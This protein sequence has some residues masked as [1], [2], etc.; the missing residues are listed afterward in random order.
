MHVPVS[1]RSIEVDFKST[2]LSGPNAGSNPA[3]D[4][5]LTQPIRGTRF[6]WMAAGCPSPVE[7]DG[8]PVP[9]RDMAREAARQ[10]KRLTGL[11][12][13]ARGAERARLARRLALVTDSPWCASCGEPATYRLDDA[14]SDSFTTVRNANRAWAFGG[15][16]ACPACLWACKTLAL[17]CGLFFARLPDAH[18]R[19][20]FWFVS[21]RPLPG[22]PQTRP[23]PLDVLLHPPPPPFVAGLPLYGIDHGG[24]A[25]AHRAV[26]WDDAG[27]LL[28]PPSPL[29]KLQSKHTAI[30][31]QVSLDRER[32]HLQID[33]AADVMVDVPL[34]RHLRDVCA[35]LLVDLRAGGV[36]AMEARAA[37]VTGQAP[38]GAPLPLLS[39]WTER[40]APLRPT[41]G[42]PW[43]SFFVNLLPMPDLPSRATPATRREAGRE[44]RGTS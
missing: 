29:V 42:A 13:T 30:Y 32:Y 15:D 33:D 38:V 41:M 25:N 12:E 27:R 3:G 2:G 28:V 21:L 23:D 35:R 43:W 31:T 16:A 5:A 9:P 18:G 8:S 44:S 22:L 20:G 40:T 11:L 34:W 36:G 26:W 10:R 17:R 37:L 14:I 39:R 19:G 1:E 4:T 7:T 6:L 24:E